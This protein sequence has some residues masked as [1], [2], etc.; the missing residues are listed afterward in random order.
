[1]EAYRITGGAPLKGTIRVAGAKNAASKMIIASLLTDEPIILK[2][3]PRQQESAITLEILEAIGGQ[4]EWLGEHEVRLT[5]KAIKTTEVTTLS[6]KNR[7]SILAIAPLLH[8]EKNAFV[9]RLDG[10]K[11]G[12]RPVN[13]HLTVLERMG[14]KVEVLADGF[15][16]TVEN[17]LSG[18]LVDLPYPSV[19][20]TETA[21]FAGVLAKGRTVIRNAAMEPE[22]LAIIMMLQK[23]GA[24]IQPKECRTIEIV[25]VSKLNGCEFTILPDSLEVA[26]YGS[27][28][29]ATGGDIFVEDADHRDMMTYLNTFRRVG[30]EYSIEENGIRFI[31]TKN[32]TGI[33]LETDTHPGFRTDWQQPFVVALT[34]A[35][36]TSVVHETVYEERFGYTDALNSMGAD[37]SLFTSCL[38]EVP[39][40]FKDMNHKHSAVIKGPTAL[41]SAEVVVPDIRA[42][43]AYVI[44]A[45]VA[46]GTSTLTNIEH[47]ERGYEN[48]L[49]KLRGIGAQIE[50][51][52]L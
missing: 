14:A 35:R 39:C 38:G 34:Q 3:V 47:L 20:A 40:R 18:V 27:L 21:I 31:G 43:L 16:A 44:A 36:G 37:I 46:E 11:I 23:M 5:T 25:G 28:V 12:A 2:N 45:L 15:K 32:I 22:I 49:E 29:L 6:R 42:G 41:H 8:R 19:G 51:I 13:F 52:T 48:L 1:M 26:S 30:G 10:D 17:S 9:P 50:R 4:I 7:I 24:I 33:E